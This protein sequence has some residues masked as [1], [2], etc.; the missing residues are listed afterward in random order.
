METQP[1]WHAT[2]YLPTILQM[3]AAMFMIDVRTGLAEG[4]VVRIQA[5]CGGIVKSHVKNVRQS[6]DRP[7][8]R[9]DSCHEKIDLFRV[10]NWVIH[11]IA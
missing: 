11:D 2:I 4:N 6:C 8:L 5:T 10:H 3:A 1:L 9:Y 7:L